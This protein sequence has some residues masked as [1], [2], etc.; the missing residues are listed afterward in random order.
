MSMGARLI[1]IA[2]YVIIVGIV[3]VA[4]FLTFEH[5]FEATRGGSYFQNITVVLLGTVLT[6]V[7]TSILLSEQSRSEEAKERNVEVFS[8]MVAR[9]ERMIRLLV[10]SEEQAGLD[11]EER[12]QL[13]EA[14]YDMSLFCS[15]QTLD[16][17]ARFLQARLEPDRASGTSVSLFEVVARYR[18]DMGL[19]ME[20]ASAATLATVEQTILEHSRSS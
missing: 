16:A 14:F 11:E 9:Y 6:V 12:R 2:P 18:E 19:P 3:Y 7:I 8:R 15:P 4:A 10:R 20:P 5:L 13:Q 17:T 1:R